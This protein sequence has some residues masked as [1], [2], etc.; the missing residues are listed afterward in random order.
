M[1][2][3]VIGSM[4]TGHTLIAARA[5][6]KI[7]FHVPDEYERFQTRIRRLS[8]EDVAASIR[9][10]KLRECYGSTEGTIVLTV[11]REETLNY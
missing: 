2:R 8:I 9:R 10:N 7:I 6:V 3:S 1:A 11:Q 4:P 5:S